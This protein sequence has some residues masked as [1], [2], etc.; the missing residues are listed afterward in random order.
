MTLFFYNKSLSKPVE[1]MLQ[2]HSK[3]RFCTTCDDMFCVNLKFKE[4]IIQ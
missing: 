4:K 2:R 3:S 1:Y